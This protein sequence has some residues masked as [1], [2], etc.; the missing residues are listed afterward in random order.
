MNVQNIID[1][2]YVPS[3]KIELR[4]K[5][6]GREDDRDYDVFGHLGMIWNETSSVPEGSYPFSVRSGNSY[7]DSEDSARQ[8][9][10][11]EEEYDYDDGFD[12]DDGNRRNTSGGY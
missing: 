3:W 4:E 2:S 6:F 10:R 11:F 12:R 9:E 1:G 5:L 7:R 8:R